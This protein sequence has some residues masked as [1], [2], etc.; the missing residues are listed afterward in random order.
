MSVNKGG[1]EKMRIRT[2]LILIVCCSGVGVMIATLQH[3]ASRPATL[4]QESLVGCRA[5]ARTLMIALKVGCPFCERSHHLYR[6]VMQMPAVKNDAVRP[7]IVMAA[8]SD[9]ARR[10]ADR[11]GL[12]QAQLIRANLATVGV[13]LTPTVI[14]LDQNCRVLKRWTGLLNTTDQEDLLNAL[15]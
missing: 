9:V 7:V 10:Y 5:S 8:E 4:Q 11:A 2:L 6:Q 15:R 1:L 13:E 14:L 12:K 3:A